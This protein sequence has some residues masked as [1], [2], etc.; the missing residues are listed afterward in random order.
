MSLAEVGAAWFSWGVRDSGRSPSV[1]NI[2]LLR[3]KTSKQLL[4]PRTRP[5]CHPSMKG[6]RSSL[7]S[8]GHTSFLCSVCPQFLTLYRSANWSWPP[9]RGFGLAPLPWPPRGG[10]A[11]APNLRDFACGIQG[12]SCGRQ[13]RD[14]QIANERST[15]EVLRKS[16]LLTIYRLRRDDSV[17]LSSWWG[18]GPP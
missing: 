4:R 18:L 16:W 7:Q 11:P 13:P 15:H 5:L 14:V 17:A 9:G 8:S 6:R 1:P 12:G 2:Y 10:G 3:L